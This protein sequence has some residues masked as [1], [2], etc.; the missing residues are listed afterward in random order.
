M[1]ERADT[2]AREPHDQRL[3]R[4]AA[5]WLHQR[6]KESPVPAGMGAWVDAIDRAAL[7][8]GVGVPPPENQDSGSALHKDRGDAQ[9]Y[10]FLG[11]VARGRGYCTTV[12]DY[13]ANGVCSRCECLDPA[14]FVVI[15]Y[16]TRE[17]DEQRQMVERLQDAGV[18]VHRVR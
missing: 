1:A 18:E 16:P 9:T 3:L 17:Q 13:D 14:R 12:C 15:E 7:A 2:G 10:Q 8:A 11:P 6:A 4:E 5:D